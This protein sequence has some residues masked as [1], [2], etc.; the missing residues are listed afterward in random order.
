MKRTTHFVSIL[1]FCAVASFAWTQQ[2]PIYSQFY[3]NDYVINPATTGMNE[4]PVI[5]AGVR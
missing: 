2:L 5:Q 3:W 4:K 1:S